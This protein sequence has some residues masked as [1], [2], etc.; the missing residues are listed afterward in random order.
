M[1]EPVRPQLECIRHCPRDQGEIALLSERLPS[2]D[3]TV[4][5]IPST[6]AIP[7][8]SSWHLGDGGRRIRNSKS[9]SATQQVRGQSGLHEILGWE[10]KERKRICS[11]LNCRTP[12]GLRASECEQTPRGMESN[13]HPAVDSVVGGTSSHSGWEHTPATWNHIIYRNYEFQGGPKGH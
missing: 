7:G 13:L 1:E 10:E 9:S 2:M 6:V 5:S 12:E 8:L 4:G 11:A 3:G